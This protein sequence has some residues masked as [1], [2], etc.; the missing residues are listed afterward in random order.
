MQVECSCKDS[1]DDVS[2]LAQKVQLRVERHWSAATQQL[3]IVYL[4]LV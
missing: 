3:A 4:L 2:R 1:L